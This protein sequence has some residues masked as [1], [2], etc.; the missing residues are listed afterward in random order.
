VLLTTYPLAILNINNGDD[1]FQSL[2]EVFKRL[3]FINVRM[4][5]TFKS[6]E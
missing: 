6:E 3:A 5:R 2:W 4:H 1:T